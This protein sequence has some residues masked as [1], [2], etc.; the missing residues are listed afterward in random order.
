MAEGDAELRERVEALERAV[1]IMA[2]LLES[3]HVDTRRKLAEPLQA[4]RLRHAA[5]APAKRSLSIGALL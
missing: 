1:L 2:T 5:P 4:M 3:C